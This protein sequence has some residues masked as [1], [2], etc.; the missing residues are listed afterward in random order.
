MKMHYTIPLLLLWIKLHVAHCSEE[1]GLNNSKRKI[2]RK[3]EGGTGTQSTLLQNNKI[4]DNNKHINDITNDR[5]ERIHLNE[6]EELFLR[7]LQQEVSTSYSYAPSRAPSKSPVTPGEPTP[8]PTP[9]P[10]PDAPTP[11]PNPTSSCKNSGVKFRLGGE[12]STKKKNCKWVATKPDKVARRC[13][14]TDVKSHCP[15]ACGTCDQYACKDSEKFWF[16]WGKE[17]SRARS[18]AWVKRKPWK[19]PFRC[20]KNGVAATCRETC[21][22]CE[23]N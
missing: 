8:A 10:N 12:E 18:C 14:Y 19:I 5:D 1:S 3:R 22:W 23:N 13:A 21:G 6:E 16:Y 11:A 9:N 7:Y 20:G 4:I 15:N 2:G 17:G